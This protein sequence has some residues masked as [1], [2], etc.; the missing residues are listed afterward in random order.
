VTGG[1]GYIGRHLL[2][3]LL[4]RGHRVRAL[5]RPG[6]EGRLPA[7]CDVVVG[8]PLDRRTFERDIRPANTLVHLV[9]VPHPS[10]GKAE[11][12]FAIDL[13]AAQAAI[14]AAVNTQLRHF[15]YV[16]VAQPAPVMVAYQAARAQA[17]VHLAEAHLNATILRPWYVLGPGRQWPRL[18]GPVYALAERVPRWRPAALRLGLVTIDQMVAALVQSIE[19]PP[20]GTQFLTVP[21]IRAARFT[22]FR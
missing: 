6:S 1:T 14:D 9:G 7:D 4:A 22:P 3:A 21:D 13:V 12:F 17:E 18:L 2:P 20:Y 11:Q 16:S 8:N 10:P 19:D 5:V 15:V